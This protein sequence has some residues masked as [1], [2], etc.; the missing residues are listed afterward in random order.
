MDAYL[1]NKVAFF[2]YFSS[3]YVAP[4]GIQNHGLL[5]ESQ[6]IRVRRLLGLENTQKQK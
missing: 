2:V 4:K 6:E 1:V 3:L 5:N